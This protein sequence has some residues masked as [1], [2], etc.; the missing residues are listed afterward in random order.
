MRI[1]ATRKQH[2]ILSEIEDHL[3]GSREGWYFVIISG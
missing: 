1:R 3:R 2:F